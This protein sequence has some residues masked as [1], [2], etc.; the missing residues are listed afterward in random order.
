MIKTHCKDGKEMKTFH[1]FQLSVLHSSSKDVLSVEVS[2][3]FI[4]K[5]LVGSHQHTIAVHSPD[6]TFT[7]KLHQ[8]EKFLRAGILYSGAILSMAGQA[9]ESMLLGSLNWIF[10]ALGKNRDCVLPKKANLF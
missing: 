2:K 3:L 5:N 7:G 10:L 9:L 4:R 1:P 6:L 8:R